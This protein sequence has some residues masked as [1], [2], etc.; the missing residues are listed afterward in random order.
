MGRIIKAKGMH[1]SEVQLDS[2]PAKLVSDNSRIIAREV[3][4]AQLDARQSIREAQEKAQKTIIAAKAEQKVRREEAV[5]KA[6]ERSFTAAALEAVALFK[7]RAELF[8][9]MEQD[10]KK[11]GSAMIDKVVGASEGASAAHS[12]AIEKS[13]RGLRGQRKFVVGLGPEDM[14]SLQEENHLEALKAI[15]EIIL[16]SETTP[17]GFAQLR[18]EFGEVL[19]RSGP[20]LKALAEF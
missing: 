7:K 3:Y 5:A 2:K 15:P 10:I 12:S 16:K 8:A 4:Q 19:A 18:F 14:T 6:S 13:I 9:E 1:D 17:K 20:I 11:L